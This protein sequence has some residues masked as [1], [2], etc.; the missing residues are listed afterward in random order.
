MTFSTVQPRTQRPARRRRLA[1]GAYIPPRATRRARGR[2]G[3]FLVVPTV[4]MVIIFFLFPMAN[5]F[6]YSLIDFDGIDLNPP[7]VGLDNYAT[8]LTDPKVGEALQHNLVWIVLGTVS[9]MVIGLVL[10]LLTWDIRRGSKLYRAAF[11]LPY[12][13]PQV[14]IGIVWGWIYDPMRGWLNKSLEAIGLERLQT[15]WLGDPDVALFAVLFTAIWATF[16]FAYVILLSALNN[17]DVEL[18]DA[19]KIDGARWIQR[20]WYIVLP[21]IMPVFIMVTTLTLIGGFSVFDIIFV[22]TGGGPARASEVLG[23]YSYT[24]AFGQSNISY[25]TTLALLIT[26]LA[27]P[28]TVA[29]N[30]LQRRLSLEGAAS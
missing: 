8:M 6:Y 15:G 25:G 27:V 3:F 1:I 2:L 19:S 17:V 7:F 13:L 9:P 4:L 18:L 24:Q 22:M 23:T 29:L 16:G 20:V 28:F 30:Y 10:A 26:G 11:F 14:V 5:A 21:Q 12:V